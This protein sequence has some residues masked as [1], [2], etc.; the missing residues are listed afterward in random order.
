VPAERGVVDLDVDEVLT[1]EV[2][3]L[4]E[5]EHGRDVVVVL[6]LGRLLRLRLEQQRAGEPDRALV[7]GHQVHEPRELVGSRCAGRC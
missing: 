7:L 6:V 3:A 2:V 5:A 1:D 4:E